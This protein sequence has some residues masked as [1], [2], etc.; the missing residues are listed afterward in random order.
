MFSPTQE[1]TDHNYYTSRTY[2]PFDS[3]SRDLWVNIDQMEKDK[4]KIHGI[5]SNTHRQAAVRDLLY[6]DTLPLWLALIFFSYDWHI[7]NYL[8]QLLLK[9]VHLCIYSSEL[10]MSVQCCDKK[11]ICCFSASAASVPWGIFSSRN[12]FQMNWKFTLVVFEV[13]SKTMMH[14]AILLLLKSVGILPLDSLTS[15]LGSRLNCLTPVF[16]PNRE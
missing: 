7:N 2:G 15:G 5:L 8:G 3:I 1:D 9:V 14:K 13:R 11:N 6:I 16:N 10:W 12:F 4:V